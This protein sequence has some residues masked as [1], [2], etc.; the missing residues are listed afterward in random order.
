ME[1]VIKYKL[2]MEVWG[3]RAKP[4]NNIMKVKHNI[5]PLI[6]NLATLSDPVLMQ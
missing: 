3:V 6:L 2:E 5:S 4:K 1:I